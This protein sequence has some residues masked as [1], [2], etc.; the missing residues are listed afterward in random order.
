MLATP[1]P[2]PCPAP[3]DAKVLVW[4]AST[5][6]IVSRFS[7]ARAVIRDVSWHPTMPLLA[8][9]S[10]DGGLRLFGPNLS[11]S[12]QQDGEPAADIRKV[13]A[14]FEGA[15]SDE[16]DEVAAMFGGTEDEDEDEDGDWGDGQEDSSEESSSDGE[17]DDGDADGDAE[18]EDGSAGAAASP[19]PAAGTEGPPANAAGGA[20]DGGSDGGSDDDDSAGGRRRARPPS[21][22]DQPSAQ[23][24]KRGDDA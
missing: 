13:D 5:G 2:T 10:W 4:E 21:D 7:G 18:E 11:L 24:A 9:S 17:E 15:A 20:G 8:T 23:R 14:V 6:D 22:S 3:Q 16:A 12:K 1:N 19:G